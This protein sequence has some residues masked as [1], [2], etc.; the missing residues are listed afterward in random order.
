MAIIT[1]TQALNIREGYQAQT[2]VH[3]SQGDVGSTVKFNLYNGSAEFDVTTFTATV[4]GVRRDNAGWGPYA[5]TINAPSAVS[6]ALRAP[7]TAVAGPSLGEIVITNGSGATVGTANFAMLVEAAAFPN[8]PSYADDVSV[9]SQIL[10]YVQNTVIPEEAVTIDTTLAITGA[11][12]D[13]KAAGDTIAAI[14]GDVADL[15]E[16]VTAVD[17]KMAAMLADGGI[18]PGQLQ[19]SWSEYR[20]IAGKKLTGYNTTTKAPT[21]SDDAGCNYCVLDLTGEAASAVTV[22]IPI[23][24]GSYV[25]VQLWD[26]MNHVLSSYSCGNAALLDPTTYAATWIYNFSTVVGNELVINLRNMSHNANF[27]ATRY[28]AFTFGGTGYVRLGVSRSLD[29]LRVLPGQIP[30]QWNLSKPY[31]GYTLNSYNNTTK[32]PTY[33]AASGMCYTVVDMADVTGA[34]QLTVPLFPAT[35]TYAAIQLWDGWEHVYSSYSV[36]NVIMND[37]E[38]Y[39]T[40]WVWNIAR[41][42]DGKIIINLDRVRNNVN[43]SGTKY[44]AFSFAEADPDRAYVYSNG[45]KQLEWFTI[46]ETAKKD[47]RAYCPRLLVAD[48][49][50]AVV[51]KELNLYFC[52]IYQCQNWKAANIIPSIQYTGA[53]AYVFDDRISIIP[54]TA[55]TFDLEIWTNIIMDDERI[56]YKKTGIQVIVSAD[57]VPVGTKKIMFLGDSRTDYARLSKPAKTRMGNAIELVGTLE[58]DGYKHEGR[59]GWTAERYC[60]V[61]TYGGYTNPFYNPTTQTFDFAYYLQETLQPVPNQVNIL[62]GLNGN[63]SQTNINYMEIMVQSIHDYDPSI[64]VTIMQEY[65]L[66]ADCGY[67]TGA[68]VRRGLSLLHHSAILRQFGGREA[69]NIFVLETG[70]GIDDNYDFPH[71]TTTASQYNPAEMPVIRDPLHLVSYGY[72]KL[73]SVW[74]AWYLAH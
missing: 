15:D 38:S 34:T 66:T 12:A 30:S 28:I 26:S 41:V 58:T 37:R 44:I 60:T 50:Y 62:L 10:S 59:S 25:A 36:S 4:H 19:D 27:S 2:V 43:F 31:A 9:Y 63:Y 39:P 68:P 13:S 11:A 16:A 14:A 24:D 69:E 64:V 22:S 48:T 56:I 40:R 3:V 54:T 47:V 32:K 18:Q 51:G 52:Q 20:P 53:G 49:Y 55:G 70:S 17:G 46:G 35:Y 5:C 65:A 6:F 23:F 71:D 8:G 45:T 61:A 67:G 42:E 21:I 74:A 1:Q 33:N 7:M 73:I 57:T 72:D 29:W